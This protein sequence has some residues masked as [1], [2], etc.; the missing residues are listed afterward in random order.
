M[1]LPTK[2]DWQKLQ[3]FCTDVFVEA[4]VEKEKA[5]VVAESLIQADLRGVASHGVVRTAIYLKRIEESMINPDADISIEKENDV[6][7][8]VNGNNNFGSVV[9]SEALKIALSKAKDQGISLVGVKGSNHFGTGAYYALKAIEQNMILLVVSNASQTMP[10]TGG[11]RPFLGTNPI[12]VGVPAGNSDPFVLDMATSL[13]A[14]GKII[15]AAQKGESIPIGW[16][17]DKNGNPTTDAE[18]ALEGSVL[19]LAGPKGYAISMFIDILSGVLT[20]A[21]FGKYVNNMYENWE[22][23]QNVGHSFIAIDINRFMQLKTF[24]QRMDMYIEDIKSEPKADGVEEILIPGE[25]ESRRELELK[26]NGIEL[27]QKVAEEL[28]EIGKRYG[29]SLEDASFQ[30]QNVK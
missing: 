10:P 19:P 26:E 1:G 15:V 18:E 21:G 9:G 27:P 5:K 28:N 30:K 17:V 4:G 11:V 22:D 23:P 14:R 20:G 3:Q 6:T 2:F 13:V 29:L 7:A 24:K 12:A 8:L 25:I 16:A